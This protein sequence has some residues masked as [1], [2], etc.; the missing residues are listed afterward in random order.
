MAK[1]IDREALRKSGGIYLKRASDGSFRVDEKSLYKASGVKKQAEAAKTI[2][3]E[4]RARR[5]S[6]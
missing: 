3:S 1:K 2:V 6:A 4:M 5:K